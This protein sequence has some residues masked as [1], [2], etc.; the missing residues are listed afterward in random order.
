MSGVT[1]VGFFHQDAVPMLI[2]QHIY[3]VKLFL[4]H[5]MVYSTKNLI[6]E[7][8][9]QFIPCFY[10]YMV[11]LQEAE[12]PIIAKLCKF[13][14]RQHLGLTKPISLTKHGLTRAKVHSLVK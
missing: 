3:D 2:V 5:S 6:K 4:D 1:T 11:E 13:M 12:K 8:V 9:R 7:C 10:L 14:S